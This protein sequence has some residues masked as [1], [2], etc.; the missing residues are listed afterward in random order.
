MLAA[1]RYAQHHSLT[2]AASNLTPWPCSLLQRVFNIS[3]ADWM[4][5]TQYEFVVS[6]T[7]D[8]C[9]SDNSTASSFT[10]PL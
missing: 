3:Q 2:P 8:F 4:R 5:D 7:N 9:E 10:T 6:A 1:A